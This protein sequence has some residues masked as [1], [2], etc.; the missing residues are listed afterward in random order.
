MKITLSAIKAD[1]GSV[2]G[3]T[4]PAPTMLQVVQKD[5]EQAIKKGLIIDGHAYHTGDD[6]ALIMTHTYG[7]DNTEIHQFAWNVFLDATKVA[8]TY[9]C[10]GA[11]QDLL[12]DAPSGNIRGA[13]PGIAEIDFDFTQKD[14]RPAESFLIMAADKCGPGVFNLPFFLAFADPMY[15]SGLMLPSMIQ[16]FRFEIVDMNSEDQQYIDELTLC[17]PEDVYHIAALLRDNERFGIST[18]YSRAYN[19]QAVSAST[20]RLHAIAGKYVG[21]DDPIAI[22]RTQG[23]FPAP[24]EVI[25]PFTKAHYVGGG[26]RGSHNMPLMPVPINTPVTGPYCLP[27]ISCIGFSLS[28]EGR[29]SNF[30]TDFFDNPAWDYVRTKAQEKALI[31]REQGWSGPAMLHYSELEYGAMKQTI[32]NILKKFSKQEYKCHKS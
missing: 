24:E 1:V 4:T 15:C 23:I 28:P 21:K 14:P 6:I 26:A 29:F 10:Y 30:Y 19:E 3:H 18:I 31:I 20:D 22:V 13:G 17:A 8:R 25:S 16:G 11:G 7:C 2:G 27:I 12:A 32:E 5:L 9:G